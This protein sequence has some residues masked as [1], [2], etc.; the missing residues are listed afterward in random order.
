MIATTMTFTEWSSLENEMETRK[1]LN[2]AIATVSTS[3]LCIVH[4]VTGELTNQKTLSGRDLCIYL[5][6]FA[7]VNLP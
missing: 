7:L 3:H 6:A 2:S 4:H 5:A 1:Q